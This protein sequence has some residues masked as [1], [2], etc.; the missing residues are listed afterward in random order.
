AFAAPFPGGSAADVL[1]PNE[2]GSELYVFDGRGKHLRTL[3]G[4]TSDVVTTFTY[5]ASGR[6]TRMED[7][8]GN[9][10]TVARDA[11]GRVAQLT[12][13]FGQITT[14][15]YDAEGWLASVT[16]PIGR[17][18]SF[19]YAPGGL[20]TQRTDAGGGVHA[21][22][23]DPVG[24]LTRDATA[25]NASFSLASDGV[26]ST[27]TTG[28][29]RHEAHSFR[30][31][32]GRDEVRTYQAADGTVIPW[33]VRRDGTANV[34]FPNGTMVD[35]TREADPRLGM[36]VPY[37]AKHVVT[38]P[39]GLVRNDQQ[40]WTAQ[41][42]SAGALVELK[43]ERTSSDGRSTTVYDATMR[44][45]TSTSVEG[46]VVKETLDGE[47]RIV[48]SEYPGRMPITFAYDARG[49]LATVDEGGRQ[50]RA[51]YDPTTGALASVQNALGQ[52]TAAERDGALRLTA[53]VHA[54]GAKSLVAW[55]AMDDPVGVTPPGKPQHTMTFGKD[56]NEISYTPPGN[57]PIAFSYD[58][59][60]ALVGVTRE[61]G[62]TSSLAYDT[63][64]R[65]T[66]V[67]Y[68][69]G[70]L[71]FTYDAK[72]GELRAL[73]APG[74]SLG[75]DY[76]GVLVRSV[77]A[78][79]P[80][81]GTVSFTYDT[82]LRRSDEQVGTSS[83]K[84]S[85]DRDGLVVGAGA[86]TVGRDSASGL[87][88]GID[89][90]NAGQRFTH[91]AFGEVATYRSQGAGGNVLDV[92]LT[93]DALSRIVDKVENGVTW[94]YD[95]DVRGRLVR[96]RK[97]GVDAATYSYDA[98]G[99][100]TDGGAAIDGQDR[101]TAMNGATYTYSPTGERLTKTTG[102]GLTKYGYDG[103]GLLASV[104]VP[105]G[106]R[107]DY[108]LD[109][110]GRRIT[111]RL[112]GTVQNRF[113][114]RN[115][116]QP[117]ADVDDQGNV[118]SRYVYA[119]GELGPDAIERAGTTYMLVKDERGSIRFVID[120]TTG[121]VAQAL[122]YDAFGRVLSDSSPGFQPFGFA[123]GLYD[124]D[125][126][127]VHFG[128]REYDP[129]TG[130]FTRKDPSRFDGGENLYAY[131]AGDPINFVDPNGE[132]IVGAVIGGLEGG[133]IGYAEEGA[134]QVLDK[135]F[136]GLDCGKIRAA[137]GWGAAFGAAA[138]AARGTGRQCFAAG[139]QV[140]AESGPKAIE[141]VAV[142]DRV[143]S[144]GEDGELSYE[145]VTRLFVRADAEEVAL[146]FTDAHGAGTPIITTPEHPFRVASGEWVTAG[147][148]DIG[149]NVVTA[150][151]GLATL[152]VALSLEKRG[153]VY[154]FEVEGTHTYF[155]GDAKLWV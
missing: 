46:R 26:T 153:T 10:L 18:E 20:L 151:G 114:Y 16:D 75:F 133:A 120:A 68:P 105:G 108:D 1:M 63:A 54:D 2:D 113:L 83:A 118:V 44:V 43:G 24:R 98:N 96:V 82:M 125:T 115:A 29:G 40:V 95:Y 134:V 78:T 94:H 66:S 81:P 101:I 35:V 97:D 104:D 144:R 53:L 61:D 121:T 127:L 109:A 117:I 137:A 5:D 38:L 111:R 14:L 142:G 136:A 119:R 80:A 102:A 86:I 47:G 15:G 76:D 55:S 152:S 8:H 6:L 39:S 138:G 132:G 130:S 90:V 27:V 103:R 65:V 74:S 135:D 122:E 58:L 89:V 57:T 33:T 31:G 64:G 45:L 100:R 23:Y 79:G 99:N 71:G 56:G 21:M 36:L 145:R 131:V 93:Y 7:R 143:L 41:Q 139:T 110:L 77:A 155:V 116:L 67:T 42:D 70:Q 148:L 146:T 49:R 149:D 37:A 124:A 140:A 12:A 11:T 129:E 154:N 112:N 126:G 13:P 88:S 85:Y 92:A 72:T 87:L 3:D 84:Y 34:T 17:K 19:A 25:E 48:R 106:V 9:A 128:A 91:T 147:R 4:L 51:V 60:R 59:D 28:L 141:D 150:E 123:G 69:G 107:A 73:T 50:T 52:T 62:T 22:A 32:L 30:G